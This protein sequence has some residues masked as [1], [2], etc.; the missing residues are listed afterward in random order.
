VTSGSSLKTTNS[1]KT[2]NNI[3]I[4]QNR[5]SQ[6]SVIRSSSFNPDTRKHES[7][8][9]IGSYETYREAK[10]IATKALKMEKASIMLSKISGEPKLE[11]RIKI[12]DIFLADVKYI[13]VDAVTQTPTT[14]YVN[15]VST[16]IHHLTE[17][18]HFEKKL[19]SQESPSNLS[20]SFSNFIMLREQHSKL[21]QHRFDSWTHDLLEGLKND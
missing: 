10:F 8:R 18:S 3:M 6:H 1:S 19:K 11:G 7:H 2:P 5:I 12:D 15:G 13:I 20:I 17:D 14:N 16:I 9:F 21:H 4:S